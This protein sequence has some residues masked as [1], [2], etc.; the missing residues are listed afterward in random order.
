VDT[1][2]QIDLTAWAAHDRRKH[3]D[4]GKSEMQ[5]RITALHAEVFGAAG[6]KLTT[7]ERRRRR[8]TRVVLSSNETTD[9]IRLA[10][11]KEMGGVATEAEDVAVDVR[12]RR[13]FTKWRFTME[14]VDARVALQRVKDKQSPPQA[15]LPSTA[16]CELEDADGFIEVDIE[17][18]A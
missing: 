5:R 1:I 4:R 9:A 13:A 12:S 15:R 16:L 2:G 6:S 14:E 7:A 10:A 18:T 3:I 8:E 17:R 11:E